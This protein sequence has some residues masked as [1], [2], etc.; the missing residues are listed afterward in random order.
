MFPIFEELLVTRTM[1]MDRTTLRRR[2]KLTKV[3]IT[4]RLI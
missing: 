2:M 1:K 3:A 4:F